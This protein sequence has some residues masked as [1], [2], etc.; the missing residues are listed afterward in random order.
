MSL[1][2]LSVILP[3]YNHARYL[4]NCLGA[5]LEQS[6]QPLEI[7]IIDDASSDNSVEL[8]EAFV[9]KHSLIRFFRNERNQGVVA[10][11]NRGLELARGDYV[12]YA[13]ADD[14]VLPG[15][16]EKSLD[17]L[18]RHGQ[19]ALCCTI[20]DWWEIET[21][22]RWQVGVGM[23]D[24]PAYL[25]P[26]QMIELERRDKL[27]IAS[28]TAIMR[29]SAIVEA[30]GFIP[31]LKWHCDWFA[32]YVAAFRH[33]ICVV[34]EPLARFNIHAA[35]YYKARDRQTHRQ[36]LQRILEFL[37]R[38]E[39]RDAAERIRDSG[40]LFLFGWP[41]LKLMLRLPAYRRFITPTFLRK[42]LWHGVKL[43][44]KKITPRFAAEWYFRLAG[45]KAPKSGAPTNGTQPPSDS[46][47]HS[48]NQNPST[49]DHHG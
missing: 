8:I 33:G 42:N 6:V 19:A 43:E 34:P 39:Y 32:I 4:Q 15:F 16:F 37:A 13:A 23:T 35:S 7:I 11:M 20:G 5:L 30:G 44:L 47:R 26:E 12:Y 22:L 27:F 28:H 17:L 1:P 41:I 38:P 9:R 10:G 40:A 21:G 31:E 18:G 14:Q 36:V 25:S 45:Y 24:A 29:R 48:R 46:P 3:N 49:T 2:R